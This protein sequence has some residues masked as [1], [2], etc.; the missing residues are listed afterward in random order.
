MANEKRKRKKFSLISK[1]NIVAVLVIL[2]IV[3]YVLAQCYTVLN[4]Q[5]KTQTAVV[6]TVYD[7]IDRKSVV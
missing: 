6:S 7:T 5:F 1:Q 4:V 2:L 3:V